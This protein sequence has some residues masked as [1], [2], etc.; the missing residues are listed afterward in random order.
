MKQGVGTEDYEDYEVRIT[1]QGYSAN[2]F[3]INTES[4]MFFTAKIKK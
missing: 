1:R 4:A 3:T 2:L